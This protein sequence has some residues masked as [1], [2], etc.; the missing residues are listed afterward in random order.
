MKKKLIVA[1]RA[2]SLAI[3]QTRIVVS[4]IKENHPDIEIEIKEIISEGDKDRRT[5]L[6]ELKSTGFFTSQ[7][8]D[9]VLA[10]Q[11]DIAVHSFKDL[12]TAIQDGLTIGAVLKREFP[13]DCLVSAGKIRTIDELPKGAKIGTSSLR[14]TVQIKRLRNDLECL[15]IRGNVNTRLRKLEQ[16]DFDA[17]VLARAGLE[18]LGLGD[19]ISIMFDP[20]KFI[21]APAQ[22]AL[23]VEIRADDA[24]TKK[25]VSELDDKNTRIE[26]TAERLVFSALECG[27]HAPAG[28]FAC[29]NKSDITI[30]AFYCEPDGTNYAQDVQ[31][32]NTSDFE[33]IA[34][35]L[36]NKIKSQK[37]ETPPIK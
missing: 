26:T 28:A 27:C 33:N 37:K 23:A 29:V 16:G 2:G 20:S 35:I 34:Q 3:A 15:P 11:A 5:T 13:E 32:G 24:Q 12:P 4:A 19:K 21:P 18:R 30:S 10:G 8:E 22:G 9:A 31:S 6:W 25:I 7:L 36:A 1:T 14:R 17:I